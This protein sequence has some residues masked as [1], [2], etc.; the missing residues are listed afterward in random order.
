[1]VFLFPLC[2]DR[3]CGK[4]KSFAVFLYYAPKLWSWY[5]FPM[6]TWGMKIVKAGVCAI[7]LCMVL[8]TFPFRAAAGDALPVVTMASLEWPPYS[9]ASLPGQGVSVRVARKAFEA[10]GYRLEVRFFPWQRVLSQMG[11]DSGVIGY[12]PE[13][14]SAERRESYSYSTPIGVSPLGIVEPADK[15]WPWH[16]LRDLRGA[17]IGVV[18]GYVNTPDFD[19]MVEYRQ[20]WVE[21][22]M[23]DE[24][25][26]RKVLEGRIDLAVIDQHVFNWI[27]RS[28]RFF[29][30]R[31]D[32]VRF[33]DR[34]LGENLLYACFAGTVEGRHWRDI[35]NEGLTRINAMA[36]HKGLMQKAEGKD[37][38]KR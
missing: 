7:L 2:I 16:E 19:A 11:M 3:P 25:N 23:D 6:A 14:D 36:L 5:F 32:G 34:L 4:G 29:R 33:Q 31:R 37:S 22:V 10:M 13:Y 17:R 20:L 27:L 26:L 35:F 24:T 38:I 12:M 15:P 30:G 21:P 28:S 9:G 8:A 1:M 18:A